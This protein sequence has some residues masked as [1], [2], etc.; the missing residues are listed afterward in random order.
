MHVIG[1]RWTLSC[2]LAVV[3]LTSCGSPS[4]VSGLATYEPTGDGGDGALLEAQVV[5]TD[6][7]VYVEQDGRR[8]LPIFPDDQVERGTG[9]QLTY[10]GET[11]EDGDRI[12]LGGGGT[13]RPF[14]GASVPDGCAD[15]L[16]VWVV[17]Q[18]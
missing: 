7:C 12:A 9:E 10:H 6:G 18:G 3:V 1:A 17:A 14:E 2:A 8:M 11:Y 16:P 4:D 13:D 5:L 15:D